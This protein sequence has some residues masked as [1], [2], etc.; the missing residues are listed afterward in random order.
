M[1]VVTSIVIFGASGDLSQRKLV[2]ALYNLG[3]KKRLPEDVRIVGFARR[4]SDHDAYRE[5]MRAAV[6]E[7]APRA[8]DDAAWA[9]FAP[10][11]WYV[12]GDPGENA[13]LQ[14]LDRFL[15]QAEGESGNRLYYLAVPPSVYEDVVRHL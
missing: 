4:E 15:R 5:S 1:A 9:A 12:S 14:R 11:L 10:R 13:D 2:P 7:F 6:R 3:I 8:Y